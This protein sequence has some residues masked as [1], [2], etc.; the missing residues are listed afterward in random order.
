MNRPQAI[1]HKIYTLDHLIKQVSV[2]RFLNRKIVFTN[3]CFDILHP[4]H[5]HVL[6]TATE[7]DYNVGL[8]VGLNSDASIKRLKGNDR[9]I[10]NEHDRALMLASMY[11]V[12]AVVMFDEDTPQQLIAALQPDFL[13]KGGD[14]Q[15]HEIVGA[16]IVKA[17]GGKVVIVP[18]LENYSTTGI[19]GRMRG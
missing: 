19:I 12:D 8:I 11:A 16:D 1:H 18:Y 14:Y 3:G 15:E 2:W 9:P 4:G 6:N 10:N 5:A 17:R 13:V 7:L